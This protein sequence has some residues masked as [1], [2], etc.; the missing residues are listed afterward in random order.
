[1]RR[2]ADAD[3]NSNTDGNADAHSDPDANPDA[4]TGSAEQS[5]GNGRF[6]NANQLGL[7]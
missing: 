1:L 3:S 7:D 5:N 4:A 6:G 2:F